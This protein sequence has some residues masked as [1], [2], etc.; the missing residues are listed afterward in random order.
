MCPETNTDPGIAE[1][2]ILKPTTSEQGEFVFP[3]N[4]VVDESLPALLG[5]RRRILQ[6]RI[7]RTTTD[8]D[9]LSKDAKFYQDSGSSSLALKEPP[10]PYDPLKSFNKAHRMRRP[11]VDA[12]DAQPKEPSISPRTILQ[13]QA[14][15]RANLRLDAIDK[16]KLT[17]KRLLS[18]YGD[19]LHN[20]SLLEEELS[21]GRYTSSQKKAIRAA[22]RQVRK[23]DRS[24][25]RLLRRLDKSANSQDIPGRLVEGRI[26]HKREKVSRP[27]QNLDKIPQLA[28][29][30][31]EAKQRRHEVRINAQAKAVVATKGTIRLAHQTGRKSI[32]LGRKATIKTG[33]VTYQGVKKVGTQAKN[34][35]EATKNAHHEGNTGVVVDNSF[36]QRRI[37]NAARLSGRS[38]ARAKAK[39][40]SRH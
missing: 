28:V 20:K 13:E 39:L 19:G 9:L 1:Q 36:I 15:L 37:D 35:A 14:A 22:G 32:E 23:Y 18:L 2:L 12:P 38:Y 27:T 17:Q 26:N 40:P 30:K 10:E 7:D 8:I 3:P 34:Y 24:K 25:E 11:G 21:S 5:L 31:R 33:H 16:R 4:A 29:Q 6:L